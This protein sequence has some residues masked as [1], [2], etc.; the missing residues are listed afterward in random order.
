MSGVAVSSRRAFPEGA[1]DRQGLRAGVV[2]RLGAAAIDMLYVV[3]ILGGAYLG[4]AGFRL[5][6]NARAFSWPQPTFPQT[7]LA[8]AIV[9]V[10]LLTAAWS[11]TGRSA[12]MRVMG[13]RLVDRSGNRLG[14]VMA[15]V[16][17]VACVAFPLGLLWSGVSKRNASVPDLVMRTSVIYDWHMQVPRARTDEGAPT[18][19]HRRARPPRAAPSFPG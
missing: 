16:R 14:P 18:R 10:I 2:S 3:A 5:M 12:G 17:A 13:L 6:R 19:A 1:A 4:L 7:V 11:S 8:F 15:L 9:T